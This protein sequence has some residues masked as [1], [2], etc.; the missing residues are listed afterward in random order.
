M[1]NVYR[2]RPENMEYTEKQ[3]NTQPNTVH[4]LCLHRKALEVPDCPCVTEVAAEGTSNNHFPVYLGNKNGNSLQFVY[5]SASISFRTGHL[6]R[7]LQMEQLCATRCSCIAILW[8]NLVS[9]A[10]IIPFIASQ[11]V[12]IV[13]SL[14]FA[15]DS[16]RRLLDISSQTFV[17]KS[18]LPILMVCK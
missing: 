8:V 2:I 14:Y 11:R 5:E 9:F 3:S 12:F 13:L 7:E 15:I 18:F 1:T 6:E 17:K 10:A 4:R 16:V